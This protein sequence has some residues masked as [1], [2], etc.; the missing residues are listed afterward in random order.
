M[1]EE[2]ALP[3]SLC[4]SPSTPDPN[5]EL[6]GGCSK[7]L[8]PKTHQ[9]PRLSRSFRGLSR[10]F[11]DRPCH[12]QVHIKTFRRAFARLSRVK[13]L[14]SEHCA[15]NSA[16]NKQNKGFRT[17]PTW[18]RVYV[19]PYILS[20]FRASGSTRRPHEGWLE[21]WMWYPSAQNL[22]DVV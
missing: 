17:T 9:L 2:M 20:I 21:G 22:A 18:I 15:V 3:L 13:K 7:F 8:F 6:Y 19:H 11:H 4:P 16:Y 14:I 12:Y 10:I 1:Y 5:T